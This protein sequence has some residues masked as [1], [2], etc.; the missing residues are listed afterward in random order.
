M[1]KTYTCYIKSHIDAPDWEA[2]VE[3]DNLDDACRK[4]SRM[5]SGS[6]EDRDGNSYDSDWS[7]EDIKPFVEEVRL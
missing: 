4:F 1:A 5:A 2:E 7:P 3:A 6:W